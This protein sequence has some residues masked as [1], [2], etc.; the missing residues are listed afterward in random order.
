M[1]Y[2]DMT[3]LSCNMKNIKILNLSEIV[4]VYLVDRWYLSVVVISNKYCIFSQ[5]LGS[6][7]NKLIA[8]C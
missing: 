5:V 2:V 8:I 3:H 7:E 4:A 6:V 1:L